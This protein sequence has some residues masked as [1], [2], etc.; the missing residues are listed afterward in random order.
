MILKSSIEEAKVHSS[1]FIFWGLVLYLGAQRKI[2]GYSFDHK[3][4]MY[5]NNIICMPTYLDHKSIEKS[6]VSKKIQKH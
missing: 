2:G 4:R 1:L 6:R 3:G 5:G